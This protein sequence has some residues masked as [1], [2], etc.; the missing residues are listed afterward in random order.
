MNEILRD[1]VINEFTT[2]FGE[3]RT[4]HNRY[5]VIFYTKDCDKNQMFIDLKLLNCLLDPEV[6]FIDIKYP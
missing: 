2:I 6:S 3:V 1:Y 4:N 5:G